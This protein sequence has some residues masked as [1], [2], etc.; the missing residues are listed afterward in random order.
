VR[1][2]LVCPYSLTV[3][4]G[5]QGQVVGL[6]R[7]LEAVGHDTVVVAPVD[8]VLDVPGLRT[9]VVAVGRSVP[10]AANGS[11]APVSLNPVAAERAV[12]AIR[13]VGVDLVHLHEPLAPGAGYAC[14]LHGREPLIGTFHRAGASTGYRLLGPLARWAAGR[15]DVRCAVSPEAAATAADALGGTYEIV[16]NGVDLDRFAQAEPWPT[17]GPT[18]LFVGRHERRK[19]LGVL[20]EAFG[21]AEGGPGAATLWVVGQGPETDALQARTP[22]DAGV[23]WLG[24]VDDQ[25]LA[26]RLRGAHV[27]CAPALAGE[28][29]GMILLEAMASRTAVV[30]SDIPGYA[31]VARGHADLVAPGDTTALAA[32][33]ARALADAQSGT[34]MSSPIA[35]DRAF[36]HAGT[37]SMARLAE[38]YVGIYETA[39]ARPPRVR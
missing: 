13:R 3:P 34:G 26:S 23:Q 30:A 31:F 35:L 5:V 10:V 38:R 1:I 17:V 2:A 39:L 25:E 9:P 32:A 27:L 6:A 24:R 18:V 7:A 8:G 28:S 37:W 4:G 22:A 19:G 21:R 36:D 16:G 11:V 29:F 12:R 33:L 15:L 14:L 20:L